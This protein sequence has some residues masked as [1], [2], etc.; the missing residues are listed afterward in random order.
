MIAANRPQGSMALK[1]HP[2]TGSIVTV[3]FDH[4]FKPPEM[5]KR[6]LAVVIST[7][8]KE[9]AG[10]CTIIPLSTSHPRKIMP[11]HYLLNIPFTLP[12]RW[13]NQPRWVKGDMIYSLGFHRIDLL[14]LGKDVNGKR[15]YQ[16]SKI[17]AADLSA[18]KACV[19]ASLN[20]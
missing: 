13:G 14:S 16:K 11:Y 20:L 3:D 10:L 1:Y 9:R 17:N 19:R 12:K 2:P 15:R 8:I 5:V 18:I 4:G 6:R 7:P